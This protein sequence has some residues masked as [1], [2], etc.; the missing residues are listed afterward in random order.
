MAALDQLLLVEFVRVAAAGHCFEELV[1][2]ARV[3]VWNVSHRMHSTCIE[4]IVALF[5]VVN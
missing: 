4:I 3:D 2:L 1:G 5:N